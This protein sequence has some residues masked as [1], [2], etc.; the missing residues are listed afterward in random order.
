MQR[1]INGDTVF[2]AAGSQSKDFFDACGST[3]TRV[4][5]LP[6][7]H[8]ADAD[9][10]VTSNH[11]AP[12]TTPARCCNLPTAPMYSNKQQKVTFNLPREVPCTAGSGNGPQF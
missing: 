3:T 6:S 10:F 1:M 12:S 4:Q 5:H 8:D 2:W 11:H 7:N 9:D